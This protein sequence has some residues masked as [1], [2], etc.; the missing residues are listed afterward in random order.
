MA[1]KR[2]RM[3]VRLR[4]PPRAAAA[5]A[6]AAAAGFGGVQG[7][8]QG[9]KAVAAHRTLKR[10]CCA[11]TGRIHVLEQR[12]QEQL[13]AHTAE[14]AALSEERDAL[15]RQAELEQVR[16]K[17]LCLCRRCRAVCSEALGHAPRH[18]AP[19]PVRGVTHDL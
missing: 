12:L 1:S 9:Q 13:A 17:G 16:S 11:R 14:A 7:Q 10:C 5:A 4:P 8:G 15:R 3:A 19:P 2:W 18:G 6:A